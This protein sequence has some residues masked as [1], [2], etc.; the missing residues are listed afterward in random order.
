M[1][2]RNRL[3][4]RA[5]PI[6]ATA[7]ALVGLLLALALLRSFAAD[8]AL[9][10]QR[11]DQQLQLI[12]AIVA[13]QLQGDRY[14]DI[15]PQLEHLGLSDRSIASVRLTAVNGFV[16][17]DYQRP[18]AADHTVALD[19]PIA[20]SYHRAAVLRLEMDLDAV[21][22]GQTLL[23]AELGAI[24]LVVC[25]LLAVV[26]HIA[27]KRIREAFQLQ[28][29]LQLVRDTNRTLTVLSNCNQALV[30]AA[31]ER[32]LMDDM[33]RI[34]V[35][36]GGYTLAWI[37]VVDADPPRT[38]RPTAAHGHTAY[39][40]D[41]H[42]ALDDPVLGSGPTGNAIRS[43]VPVIIRDILVDAEVTPW[44]AAA[45]RF[46]FRSSI[47]L[48]L[49]NS[50]P[51]AGALMIYANVPLRF[52]EDEVRLLVELASD[53][54]YGIQS[55][56]SEARRQ[57]AE[58]QVEQ[59]GRR[60]RALVENSADGVVLA[61]RDGTLT[62]AGPSITVVLGYVPAELEGRSAFEFI[63]PEDAP[64]VMAALEECAAVSRAVVQARARVRNRAGA[65]RWMEGNFTNLLDDPD[66]AGMVINFRDIT[67]HLDLERGQRESIERFDQIAENVSE[68]FWVSDPDGTNVVYASPAYERIWKR[69]VADL[70][71]DGRQWIDA[72]HPED[73]ERILRAVHDKMARG[74]F[75]E[76]YRVVHPDGNIRWV[77]DRGFPVRNADGEIYRIVGTAEDI[78]DRKAAALHIQHLN[79]IYA[80]LSGINAL[81]VRVRDRDELFR[82]ACHLA[83]DAGQFRVAWIG[84]LDAAGRVVSPAA[85][86]S[87]ADDGLDGV[88]L[89]SGDGP[90]GEPGLV[91][92]AIAERS[93]L[94]SNDVRNDPYVHYDDAMA[95]RGVRSLAVMPLVIDHVA[96][97]VFV[98][99]S[100]DVGFF[101]SAEIRLLTEL[102]GDIAFALEHIGKSERVH[103]LAYY[104]ELTGLPNRALFNERLHQRLVAAAPARDPV[105]VVMLDVDRFRAVNE[106][107]GRTAGDE[108]I[109]QIARRLEQFVVDPTRVARVASN[110]FAVVVPAPGGESELA[111]YVREMAKACLDA[112]FLLEADVQ[113]RIAMKFGIALSPSDGSDAEVLQ[114]NAEAAL[115]KAKGSGERFLFYAPHM[116]EKVAEKLSLESRLQAALE[117]DEFVLHYQPKI[118]VQSG[119]VQGVEALLRWQSPDLG[120]VQPMQFIPILEETGLIL[121][122]GAWVMRRAVL[123]HRAWVE[124]GLDAPRI[125]VNVSAIQLHRGDFVQ[126]LRDAMAENPQFPG[127]DIEITESLLM[128]DIE[129][130]VRK[131]QAV[132]DMGIR[133]AVDDFGTGYSSFRYLAE[134]PAHTLKIDR[135]FVITMLEDP[136]VMS[137]VSIMI[138][139]AHSLQLDVVAEGV[140]QEEQARAL[141][142]LG[143]DQ[144]QGY[145]ISRPVPEKRLLEF[146]Q[147]QGG[148]PLGFS[149]SGTG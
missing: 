15:Q 16:I 118:D 117:N 87:D 114:R 35:E 140:D 21:Y 139:T 121:D 92:S 96:V 45:R 23:A 75:D 79:R 54:S 106:S 50:V 17:G 57:Q 93:M 24:Y 63:H 73:R 42:I 133:I 122:V 130:N 14:Q 49:G 46:D 103:Y 19:M 1:N 4:R 39:L 89:G 107:L 41:L 144:I 64:Q 129:E 22:A 47:A 141:A 104:D 18:R 51:A 32:E 113:L 65:W 143:C 78:T 88:L 136:K 71:H 66:V 38:V 44:R 13:N 124:A 127:L 58:R 81:I 67:E 116:N 28:V 70:L 110:Q 108:L 31:S 145:L 95:A 115:R 37:G 48:P 33:C 99:F 74:Q 27:L 98:L 60:F 55:L 40:D 126:T 56:R 5:W 102:S 76:E 8:F 29:A 36:E 91:H 2:S 101:N 86:S 25:A 134:V 105:G 84:M 90:H 30:R 6:L 135:S 52:H 128:E 20:Y 146:L 132:R 109:R 9:A 148:A 62:F 94:V 111:H 10:R 69:P 80:L 7:L 53:L 26:T 72:I 112:P 83:I 147:Q 68:A 131:L 12:G 61:A 3:A 137:L 11:A 43:G 59:Q 123:D 85:W 119:A 77:R 149:G 142:R 138:T 120:L 97:G 82:Q 100:G 125:A 34:L